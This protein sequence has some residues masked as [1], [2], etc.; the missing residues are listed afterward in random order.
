MPVFPVGGVTPDT[1]RDFVEAG[2]AGFGIGSA[3][4]KPGDTPDMVYKKAAAFVEAWTAIHP[5]AG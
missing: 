5:S 2:A 1:M 4:F 3:V